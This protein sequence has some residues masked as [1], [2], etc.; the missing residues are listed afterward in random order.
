[1]RTSKNLAL[2][3]EQLSCEELIDMNTDFVKG[4]IY[5]TDLEHKWVTPKHTFNGW[6]CDCFAVARTRHGFEIPNDC[7]YPV[8]KENL[9]EPV[10]IILT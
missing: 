8:R 5:K 3:T 9:L 1:M 10:C 4:V 2:R 7:T 6:C